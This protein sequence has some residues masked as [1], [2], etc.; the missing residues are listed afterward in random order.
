MGKLNIQRH[1]LTPDEAFNDMLGYKSE[2]NKNSI[3]EIEIDK[4]IPFKTKDNKAQPF[5]LYGEDEINQLAESIKVSGVLEPII[6][7]LHK[8]KTGCYEIIAGHNRT[9]ASKL[10]GLLTVPCV[11]KEI[12]DTTATLIM[13]DTNLNQ[14]QK[15][16][17]SEKAYAYQMQKECLDTLTKYSTA[18]IAKQTGESRKNIQ[19][20]L[21]LATIIPELMQY[22][23]DER[24]QMVAGVELTYLSNVNQEYLAEYLNK[25]EALKLNLNQALALRELENE[26]NLYPD[27]LDEFFN[28]PKPT[29]EKTKTSIS[30]KFADIEVFVDVE[31]EDLG[32]YIIRALEFYKEHGGDTTSS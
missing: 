11:V 31:Q 20:Y 13:V 3:A 26:R 2:S 12:D 7:R 6:V 10:A 17:P 16:L 21:R 32:G 19:R 23:D 18:E 25:N 27:V 4:L 22:V 8:E 30:I 5:H 15:L 28:P 14:R 9:V 24:I 29:K 1:I